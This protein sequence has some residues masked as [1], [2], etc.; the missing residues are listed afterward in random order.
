MKRTYQKPQLLYEDFSLSGCLIASC[1]VNPLADAEG[2]CTVP[3]D[4]NND[5]G[6]YI[7]SDPVNG[8]CHV[9]PPK[10]SLCSYDVSG[11]NYGLFTS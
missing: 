1:Q 3:F 6:I 7:F 8:P 5:N 2:T 4:P 9:Q 10:G 11:E